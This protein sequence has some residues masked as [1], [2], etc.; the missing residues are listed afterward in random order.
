MKTFLKDSLLWGFILWLIGY[1]LGFAFFALVPQDQLGW[2]I[3]PI[4]T[5]ITIF[6]AYKF[7]KS[8]DWKYYLKVG[9]I[10]MLTAIVLDYFFIVW[11]LNAGQMSYYRVDVFIYYALTLLIPLIVGFY[12]GR[13]KV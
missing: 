2:Y 11:L 8:T 7:I 6:V 5:I 9:V 3:M 12:K 13:I 1:V 4:G 10:W